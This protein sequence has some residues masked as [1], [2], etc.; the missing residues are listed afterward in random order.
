MTIDF[1]PF[2]MQRARTEREQVRHS[3]GNPGGMTGSSVAISGGQKNP[4]KTFFFKKIE[5]V[6]HHIGQDKDVAFQAKVEQSR[7]EGGQSVGFA[8]QRFLV[9]H[10]REDGHVLRFVARPH[11]RHAAKPLHI[12]DVGRREAVGGVVGDQLALKVEIRREPIGL[13][14]VDFESVDSVR[15]AEV[16]DAR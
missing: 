7:D 5:I 14:G 4:Q 12:V 2:A 6:R 15:R 3:D 13:A 10:P 8:P 1:E 11:F 16:F 9:Q